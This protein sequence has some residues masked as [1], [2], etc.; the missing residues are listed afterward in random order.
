MEKEI[1]G[2]LIPK[3]KMTYLITAGIVI[4]VLA[5][6]VYAYYSHSPFSNTSTS[7]IP[8]TSIITNSTNT[9][10]LLGYQQLEQIFGGAGNFTLCGSPCTKPFKVANSIINETINASIATF[11][12][13]QNTNVIFPTRFSESITKISNASL[14]YAAAANGLKNLASHVNSTQFEVTLYN[15]SDSNTTYSVLFIK[16]L[17]GVTVNMVMVGYKGG[18]MLDV[19]IGSTSDIFTQQTE[20]RVVTAV[21]QN[22]R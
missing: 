22:L 3:S 12:L 1:N 2:Q 5:V 6:L 8:A 13:Y 4:V 7:T 17:S 15:S 14:A 10:S 18:G 9:Y 19:N 20:A 11:D 21:L 16:S